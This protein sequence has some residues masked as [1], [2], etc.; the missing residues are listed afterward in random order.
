MGEKVALVTGGAMG[1]GKAFA[2]L[3]LKRN[4]KVSFSNMHGNGKKVVRYTSLPC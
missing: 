3:L 4:Y 1:F 2:E